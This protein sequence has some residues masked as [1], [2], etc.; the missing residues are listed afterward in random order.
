M[1]NRNQYLGQQIQRSY[2]MEE[3]TNNNNMIEVGTRTHD[4][5][6]VCI[7]KSLDF[8]LLRSLGKIAKC[9]IIGLLQFAVQHLKLSSKLSFGFHR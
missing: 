1:E 3:S 9:V 8:F 4:M 5:L 6:Y 2:P 7:A